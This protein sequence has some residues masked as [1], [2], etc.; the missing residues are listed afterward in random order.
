MSVIISSHVLAEVELCCDRVII[1]NQGRI[2]ATGTAETLRQEFT[3]KIQYKVKMKGGLGGFGQLLKDIDPGMT[4]SP[5][6]KP[7]EEG[8]LNITLATL[9]T[10][11]LSERILERLHSQPGIRL[12]SFCRV[13]PS[14]EDIFLSAT[15]RSWKEVLP[16]AKTKGESKDPVKPEKETGL[17]P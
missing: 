9:R 16:S 5:M 4:W 10:E 15:R 6:G 11:D 7:D 2:V 3:K 1:I 17:L 8:F 13:E 14:L 12:R